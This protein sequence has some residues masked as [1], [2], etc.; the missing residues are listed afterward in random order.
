MSPIM[1][2]QMDKNMEMKWKGVRV[3]SEVLGWVRLL[4]HASAICK[5]TATR[6]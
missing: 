1:D 2:N 4:Q 5:S 6:L 3:V